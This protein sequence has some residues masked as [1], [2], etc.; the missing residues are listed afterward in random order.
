VKLLDSLLDA[1]VRLEGDALV[2]HVGE[3][4]YVVTASS[5]MNAYRGPLAWGQVELSSRVLT[6]DAVSSMLGQILPADQQLAL[7]E[8]GAI[9]HEIPSPAGIA[10][11]FTVVAARGGED[12]WVEVRRRPIEVPTLQVTAEELV[13]ASVEAPTPAPASAPEPNAA[14]EPAAVPEPPVQQ[15]TTIDPAAEIALQ[16]IEVVAD[17]EAESPAAD[18]ALHSNESIVVAIPGQAA[19]EFALNSVADNAIQVID[20]EPQGVPT[21]EEVDAMLAGTSATIMT[22]GMTGEVVPDETETPDEPIAIVIDESFEDETELDLSAQ[23]AP[24]SESATPHDAPAPELVAA[25]APAPEFETLVVVHIDAPIEPQAE[26]P[27]I[28]QVEIPVAA[29]PFEGPVTEVETP[30]ATSV[31]PPA[32]VAGPAFELSP[33]SDAELPPVEETEMRIEPAPIGTPLF[34]EEA[35]LAAA[36]VAVE[37][38]PVAVEPMT[39]PFVVVVVEEVAHPAVDE[40][41]APFAPVAEVFPEPAVVHFSEPIVAEPFYSSGAP[42]IAATDT[43]PV[44]ELR[45]P[46]LAAPEFAAPQFVPAPDFAFTP[47]QEAFYA[48][49]VQPP[50]MGNAPTE[51]APTPEATW[52]APSETF[53]V[54]PAVEAEVP[55]VEELSVMPVHVE[56]VPEE[57]QPIAPLDELPPLELAPE[58]SEAFVAAGD[59]L[60]DVVVH[61]PLD[62]EPAAQAVNVEDSIGYMGHEGP[63]PTPQFVPPPVSEMPMEFTPEMRGHDQSGA[64]FADQAPTSFN[65]PVLDA[66]EPV[67][68]AQASSFE[69]PAPLDVSAPNEDTA[70]PSVVV[71]MSRSMAKAESV[72]VPYTPSEDAALM[73]TL[74]AAAARGASTVYVVAQSKPMIRI[75]GEIGPLESEPTLT[76]ADVERLVMELAPPRRRDALL[77]GP[78]EWL[79]DVPEIGRVRCLTFRDHRGPG[80]LFRMFPPRA[81]SADQLGLTPEVQALCQQS[82]GLVL[83]AG[84]RASGKST[85]LNAFVDL[86]NRTRSDHVIT[87]ESQIGFVHESRRSFISQRESRGDSELAATYA[88]AALREDPDVM[89]IEDLKSAEL[90]S[91]ALEAAESG[92]LV[93]ASV[94]AASTI[95][96]IERLI[97]L[98]PADRRARARASLATALRGVI[99]QVLLRRVTGGRAAAREILLNT[100]AVS[101]LVLEGKMFQLPVALD[102]GRR[103]GMV[104]LTDSL[105]AHVREGTVQ[106][107]EAYRK[108]LDRAAL[109]AVLKRD[110]IDT[111]F[112]ERLA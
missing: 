29:A 28:E 8:F 112:V 91:A 107:A 18:V 9:E 63:E 2:M 3:K 5:S 20:E 77:N 106:V 111:S 58:S 46:E 66:P 25:A 23:M 85:L 21:E 94:S 97:E 82:D 71:P 35:V 62:I 24:S 14:P 89:M 33:P 86:I 60:R 90:V 65:T 34:S 105:A 51:W 54:P 75:D 79:C 83:V 11:R 22:S 67:M 7:T 1:I 68:H 6:F 42:Q 102:S 17:I 43:A 53:V 30:V 48:S 16:E 95:G 64:G 47:P 74:R 4:P 44:E 72:A 49:H 41:A 98:F 104:P 87:I 109:V 93:I 103:H 50:V 32:D 70:R 19:E 59:P 61:L 101:Q 69:Q 40:I 80:V 55:H 88:R 57:Q 52:P 13:A 84:A 73:Q 31:E 78:V 99:A 81:I 10:D 45:V 27:V 92:R 38:E 37:P 36:A 39:E 76:A 96:A 12:V 100:P 15:E 56:P 108:A 110:G 26:T